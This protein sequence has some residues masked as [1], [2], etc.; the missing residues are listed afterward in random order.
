MMR[1]F[2]NLDMRL[3]S[4]V[5]KATRFYLDFFCLGNLGTAKAVV[6]IFTEWT[7]GNVFVFLPGK[8]KSQKR[9]IQDF[10]F[11]VEV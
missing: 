6:A 8:P 4:R 7:S 10:V 11:L 3:Q 2:P 1:S 9:R 5:S